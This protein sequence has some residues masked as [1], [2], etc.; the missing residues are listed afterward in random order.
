MASSKSQGYFCAGVV[1]C[2]VSLR[3]TR[4]GKDKGIIKISGVVLCCAGNKLINSL[5]LSL[6]LSLTHTRTHTHARTTKHHLTRLHTAAKARGAAPPNLS[7]TLPYWRRTVPSCCPAHPKPGVGP[8]LCGET[9]V[10]MC[11]ILRACA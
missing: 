7:E 6:S 9:R 3:C 10:W 4:I 1:L 5:S 11:L 2:N 8:C